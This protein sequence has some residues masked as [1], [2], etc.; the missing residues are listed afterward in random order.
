MALKTGRYVNAIPCKAR[1]WVLEESQGRIK[2][3][4][5][6]RRGSGETNLAGIHED[7]GLIPGLIQWVKDP[8]W[9]EPWCGSK[10]WLGSGDDA[11]A[12]A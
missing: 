3:A 1:V 8:A 10:I 2:W 4:W 5:I 12:L 9:P 11:V 6:S 7:A